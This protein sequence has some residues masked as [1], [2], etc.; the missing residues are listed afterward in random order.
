MIAGVINSA[1]VL[2]ALVFVVAS[3]GITNCLT[4]NVLEQTRELGILRAMAM[5]RRQVCKMIL[6]QALAIG[7]ISTPPG[8][9]LGGLLGYG[10]TNANYAVNGMKIPYALE[11]ALLLGCIGMALVVAVLASLPPARRAGRLTIIRALQYE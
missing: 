4:M 8:V 10:M 11:P 1:W 3:L 9:F 5:K 2:L 6:S 7:V